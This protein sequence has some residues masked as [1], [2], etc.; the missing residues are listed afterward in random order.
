TRGWSC[1]VKSY[2]IA[3]LVCLI[4]TGALLAD[5]PRTTAETSNYQATT[6]HAEVIAFC[7]SLAKSSPAVRYSTFGN[8]GEGRPLP[9]L[10]LGGPAEGKRPIILLI[11]NI[12]AGEVDGKEALL[13]FARDIAT[14]TDKELLKNLVILI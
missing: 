10:V 8:S 6:R 11:G 12:H 9:L 1:N 7:E 4:S 5:L 3:G 13:A 14:G 2:L